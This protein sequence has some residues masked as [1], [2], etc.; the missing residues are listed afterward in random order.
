MGWVAV[1]AGAAALL[2]VLVSVF[3]PGPFV[4]LGDKLLAWSDLART[5]GFADGAMAWSYEATVIARLGL[6]ETS[7]ALSK[8]IRSIIASSSSSPPA[9]TARAIKP[10]SIASS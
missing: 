6:D 1:L 5:R 7:E 3:V 4:A 10:S 8:R 2:V 9:P